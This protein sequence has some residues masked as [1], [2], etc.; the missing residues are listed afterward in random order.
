MRL[1]Y[2]SILTAMLSCSTADNLMSSES[3]GS[4]DITRDPL[5]G[6]VIEP[7]ALERMYLDD[8]EERIIDRQ[9]G[10]FSPYTL[11]CFDNLRHTDIEHIVAIAE[12]YDSG[13][14][15]ATV[16][17]QILFSYDLENLTTAEPSLN[18]HQKSAKD[19]AEW[20]PVENRCWYVQTWIDIKR[21]YGLTMDQAEADAIR[22]VLSNCT[23][24]DM[25]VPSCQ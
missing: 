23:S 24:T 17:M 8:L 15:R 11:L 1:I 13:L 14:N 3:E 5:L 2:F 20:L 12:A 21:K 19:P 9:G 4:E 16:D 25:I 22:F 6:I 7:E 10:H 18:R